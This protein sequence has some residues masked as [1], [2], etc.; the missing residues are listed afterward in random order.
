MIIATTQ[1]FLA[2]V[3]D[4]KILSLFYLVVFGA[5]CFEYANKYFGIQPVW[6]RVIFGIACPLIFLVVGTV[7]IVFIFEVFKKT[8]LIKL[9]KKSAEVFYGILDGDIPDEEKIESVKS[10]LK[11][12]AK[13]IVQ[14]Y[15]AA[16]AS[17]WLIGGINFAGSQFYFSKTSTLLLATLATIIFDFFVARYFMLYTLR[18]G[19]DVTFGEGYRRVFDLIF[20]E[21]KIF[22]RITL[23]ILFTKATI[24]DGPEQIVIFLQKELGSVKNMT[25]M[26]VPLSVIQGIFW[27]LAYSYGY[28]SV[29]DAIESVVLPTITQ[30]PEVVSEILRFGISEMGTAIPLN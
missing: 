2:E 22:G 10:T 3:W 7:L 20:N 16:L 14:D 29:A 28:E 6:Q 18:T 19:E 13:F 25:W 8:R 23:A 5:N 12:R 21:S 11:S 15:W 17:M 26:L 24:W 9:M 1:R 30:Q 27:A 4:N